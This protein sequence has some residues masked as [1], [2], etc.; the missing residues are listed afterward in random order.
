[1]EL[2]TRIDKKVEEIFDEIVALRRALHKNPE[3]GLDLFETAD[4]ISLVLEKSGIPHQKNIGK[5]GI[6]SLVEGIEPG[7]CVLLRA[8]MDALPL[9]EMTGL[10]YSSNNRGLMHACGHDLHAAALVGVAKVLWHLRDHLKGSYKL[11]FQPGEET[12][13]GAEAMINDGLLENPIPQAA[14]GFHNWPALDTGYV[15]YH[16]VCSHAGSQRFSI[17]L[18]GVSGH[19]AHPHTAIDTIAAASNFILQIQTIVSREIAPTQPAVITIGRIEGG[20]VHN[21]IAEAVD[22]H[23]TIRALDSKIFELIQGSICRL[24]SGLEKG[25]RVKNQI[26]FGKQVPP[27][28][29]DKKI[30]EKVLSSTRSLLSDKNVVEMT[31]GTMGAEDFA[32]ISN[33]IP[34]AHLRIGSRIP[35]TET[36]MIHKPIYAPDEKFLRT[37]M[38]LISRIGIDLCN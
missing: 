15:T 4:F 33:E 23:G 2:Q 27:V 11:A 24:L 21:V 14:F 22:L 5:S 17:S 20:T 1:M 29:N 25:M 31:E 37:A 13:T 10:A 3:L 8:D 30:L 12:L 34:S 18:T 6:V 32:Y 7:P 9:T 35:G 36:K 16:P 26:S 38:R 19:G 28:V